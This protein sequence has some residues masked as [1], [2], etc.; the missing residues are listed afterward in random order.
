MTLMAQ[1]GSAYHI[2]QIAA[3]SWKRC[4]ADLLMAIERCFGGAREQSITLVQELS[5]LH[6]NV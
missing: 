4:Q 5:A 6:M 1:S 2:T 3:I